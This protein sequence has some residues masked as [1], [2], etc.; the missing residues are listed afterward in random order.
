[1][2]TMAVATID[3]ARFGLPPLPISVPMPTAIPT[4]TAVI[5]TAVSHTRW[6]D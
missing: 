2:A 3:K 5:N 6:F 4:Y 1:M